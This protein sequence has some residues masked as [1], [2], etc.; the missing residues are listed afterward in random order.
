M[1]RKLM[2]SCAILA[3]L[4]ACSPVAKP[5][6]A[7]EAPP[8][9]SGVPVEILSIGAQSGEA[10]YVLD[11]SLSQPGTPVRVEVSSDPDAAP[12]EGQL[13]AEAATGTNLTW[14]PEEDL[15]GRHYFIISGA[16]VEPATTAVRLLP[17]E[18]GRN[19][20]DLGGYRTEDG[21]TVKWGKLFRS[22]V[23]TGLTP[24]DYDYLSGLGIRVVCDLRTAQERSA[25][26]TNWQ[27]GPAEYLTFPDPEAADES[28]LMTVFQDPDVTPE[29]VAQAM[30]SG[31]PQI[32]REQAPA[33]R[34]MFDRLAGGDIPLAFN[35][36]AGKDRTGIGAALILTALG[37]P[38]DTVLTDYALSEK[39]V[40][41]MADYQAASSE[42]AEEGPYAFLRK[43]PPELLAPLMRSDPVYLETAFAELEAQYGSVRAFL[44]EEVD[45]TDEEIA[46]LKDRL[47][48]D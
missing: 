36:S 20:R 7:E 44:Q 2:L 37:V 24:A 3:T 9:T 30:A 43:L 8:E 1:L 47:L 10:G 4:A 14:T 17:L 38:R 39:V 18:G 27:A 33:Y 29:K 28:S 46:R 45:V 15:A 22:G 42:E 41:Y 35:C 13:I 19:F 23:M 48:V 16:D 26:P 32:A 12:G 5:A 25:E 6:P 34:E 31:Y 11:W 21:K 40:D